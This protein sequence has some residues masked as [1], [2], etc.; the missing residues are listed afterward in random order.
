MRTMPSLIPNR[1]KT[2]MALA[3]IAS[4]A[5]LPPLP[6]WAQQSTAT[7]S[8]NGGGGGGGGAGGG[9][10]PIESTVLEYQSL[11][12]SATWMD[13]QLKDVVN[14]AGHPDARV[15]IATNN[16]IAAIMQL[17]AALGQAK[18][19]ANRLEQLRSA[20][21]SKVFPCYAPVPI[22]KKPSVIVKPYALN[23][24]PGLPPF[25]V[26]NASA[27]QTLIQTIASIGAVQRSIAPAP[28]TL[29]DTSLINLVAGGLPSR[30]VYVPSLYAPGLIYDTFDK[31][32]IGNSVLTLESARNKLYSAADERILSKECQ[33]TVNKVKI[34]QTTITAITNEVAADGLLVDTYEASLFGGQAPPAPAKSAGTD[35]STS[36]ATPST[37]A[38]SSIATLQQLLNADSMLR[39]LGA[40]PARPTVDPA[41]PYYLVS[42]RSLESGGNVLTKSNLFAGSHV[43]FSGGAASTF[44][45]FKGDGGII[46]S[47]VSYGYRGFVGE[48]SM[49]TAV[50]DAQ[51]PGAKA[52]D[53]N[54]DSLPPANH[55]TSNCGKTI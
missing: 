26:G 46:C 45:V 50:S 34:N 20:L 48:S 5:T 15:V 27:I 19:I 23:I 40:T 47:G 11:A 33:Y 24:L 49:N 31:T 12:E 44:D 30:A 42:V 38:A 6:I 13:S 14:F 1:A 55:F 4:I 29:N 3:L 28:G 17:E 32:L 10:L 39:Q 37:G 35:S 53:A 43:F 41:K 36:P 25:L 16:D 2:L 18:L 54:R 7:P 21:H 22:K 52:T 51:T 8:G 9:G